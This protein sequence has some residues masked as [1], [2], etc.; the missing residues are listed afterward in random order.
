MVSLQL[1]VADLLHC[2]F[3]ISP[4][5]EVVEAG[6][7]IVDPAARATHRGGSASRPNGAARRGGTRPSALFALSHPG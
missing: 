1:S 2:R 6:R 7:A 5:N 4:I 3:A